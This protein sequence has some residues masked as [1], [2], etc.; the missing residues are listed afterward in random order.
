MVIPLDAVSLSILLVLAA[1]A[2]AAPRK[3][4]PKKPTYPNIIQLTP[5]T[6][7]PVVESGALI[8]SEIGGLDLRFIREAFEAGMLQ[9]YLGELAKTKGQTEHVRKLG[10]A[11]AAEQAAEV[12]Q[13]GKLA[14]RKGVPVPSDPAAVR[15]KLVGELEALDGL[16]F[17]KA[18]LDQ[19]LAVNRLAV[20]AY[21][22]GANSKDADIKSFVGQMLPVAK[23]RLQLASKMAGASSQPSGVP[24][25]RNTAPPAAR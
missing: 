3:S 10:T 18:V 25:F 1:S 9:S 16:K 7:T 5:A 20:S 15:G 2:I 19:F 23:A 8:S 4:T 13:L 11:L 21:E 14:A 12:E 17:D 24:Q 6:G 22:A